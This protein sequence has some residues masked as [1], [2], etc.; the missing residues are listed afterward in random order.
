MTIDIQQSL[1]LGICTSIVGFGAS[2]LLVSR[3]IG[4]RD[5][6][7][8]YFVKLIAIVAIGYLFTQV[9]LHQFMNN[10]S[11]SKGGSEKSPTISTHDQNPGGKKFRVMGCQTCHKKIGSNDCSMSTMFVDLVVSSDRYLIYTEYEGKVY[12]SAY[13]FNGTSCKL[14]RVT[15][16]AF[17]CEVTSKDLGKVFHEFDGARKFTMIGTNIRQLDRDLFGDQTTTICNLE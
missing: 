8:A 10:K 12:P 4:S 9:A 5:F 2:Y 1:I 17:V 7:G 6:K 11:P 13:E 14:S 15:K 3:L 16:H